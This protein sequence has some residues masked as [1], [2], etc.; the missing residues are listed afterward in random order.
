MGA[1]L[2]KRLIN[3]VFVL[4]GVSIVIFL[5]IRMVPSDVVDMI[6]AFDPLPPEQMAK[7]KASY[8]FDQS[9]PTQ[10]LNWIWGVLHGD[11]GTSY[12]TGKPFIEELAR[13]LPVT[14]QVIIGAEIVG[15][16]IAIP[17]GV[18]SAVRRNTWIDGAARSFALLGLSIPNFWLGTLIILVCSV[19]FHWLPPAGYVSPMEDFAGNFRQFVL[20]CVTLGFA[21]TATVMRT[22]RSA[23]LEVLSQDYIRTARA[24]GLRERVVIYVHAFKNAL[25]PVI[26]IVG[27]Q[28]GFILGGVVVVESVFALPGL[29]RLLVSAVQS[30]DYPFVQS[31]ILTIALIVAVVNIIVDLLYA[32]VNPRIR[33][34]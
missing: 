15:L 27:L 9:I 1:Y 10:Y 30:R 2:I 4:I 25:I 21:L 22:T 33:Y 7:I 28:V 3:L 18:I 24:K 31:G 23:M 32:L 34:S 8:G 11:F 13:A 20:P 19:C 26:T 5:L 14:A 17:V 6:F 12:R 16:V 29:G